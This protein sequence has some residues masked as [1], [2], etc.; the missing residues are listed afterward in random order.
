LQ[1][2]DIVF[3]RGLFESRVMTADHIAALFFD[4]KREYTKK[5]LQ[6]IKAAGFMGERRRRVNEPSIYFL[7]RKAFTL[8]NSQGLLSGFPTLGAK[9]FE[10]RAK[11]SDFTIRHELEVMDVK[12]AFHTAARDCGKC[13][14][15]EFSTWPRMY[16]FQAVRPGSGGQASLVKRKAASSF[17]RSEGHSATSRMISAIRENHPR[18]P[19][20]GGSAGS[21]SFTRPGTARRNSQHCWE[22]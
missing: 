19:W 2:R 12:A 18:E 7:T 1:N 14:V 3:L 20:R 22:N 10:S 6:K 4:G 5:R 21:A 15:R 9:S 16:E 13:T 17:W 11:V 8:L